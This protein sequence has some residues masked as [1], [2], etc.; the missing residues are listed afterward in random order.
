MMERTYALPNAREWLQQRDNWMSD[1]IQNEILEIF[2]HA[3]QREIVSEAR[4]HYFYGLT[5]DGTTDVSPSEQ[6][7]LCLQDVDSKLEVVNV[8]LRF[9]SVSDS[10]GETLFSSIEDVFVRFNLPLDERLKGFCFDGADNMSGRISG[11]QANLKEVS[12][13]TLRA[14]Q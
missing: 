6:F 11:V 12:K 8:L 3:V 2:A 5:A 9:Y 1:T 7:S 14:L 4:E 10:T 13:C